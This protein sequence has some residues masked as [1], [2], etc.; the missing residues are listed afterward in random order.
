MFTTICGRAFFGAFFDADVDAFGRDR[1]GIVLLENLKVHQSQGY[2]NDSKQQFTR[3]HNCFRQHDT[4]PTVHCA[5]LQTASEDRGAPRVLL[6][7]A[8]VAVAAHQ[9][10]LG[11]HLKVEQVLFLGE[12]GGVRVA[13]L[14]QSLPATLLPTTFRAPI[15]FDAPFP[16]PSAQRPP[17][18]ARSTWPSY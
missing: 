4:T 2:T 7:V 3:P 8:V 18:T 15:S 13:V 12:R 9:V 14:P 10:T 11:L 1:L 17:W 16:S 5:R 6:R